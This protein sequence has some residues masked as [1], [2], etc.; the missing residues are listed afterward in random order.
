MNE[1]LSEQ[2][3]IEVTERRIELQEALGSIARSLEIE[4]SVEL[5]KAKDLVE[6]ELRKWQKRYGL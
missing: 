1:H 4:W 3:V 2:K 6:L 5:S